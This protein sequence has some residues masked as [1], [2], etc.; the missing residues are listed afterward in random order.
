MCLK[1]MPPVSTGFEH[2]GLTMKKHS[3]QGWYLFLDVFYHGTQSHQGSRQKHKL[4]NVLQSDWPV[5][6]TDVK[7]RKIS[8]GG[9]AAVQQQSKEPKTKCSAGPRLDPGSGEILRG[10]C[11]V[12]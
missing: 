7:E 9:R 4:R 6:F 12:H 11:W 2:V 10:H 1:L 5:F 3:E 8:E